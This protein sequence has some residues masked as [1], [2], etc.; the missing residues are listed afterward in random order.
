MN[1]MKNGAFFLLIVLILGLIFA[2]F[3]G[4]SYKE[5]YDNRNSNNS[6]KVNLDIGVT[7]EDEHNS[8]HK[9]NKYEKLRSGH[10]YDNYD[11][12]SK[13]S[14]PSTFYGPNG[15]K[16]TVSN[17][18][19]Q[20]SIIVTGSNGE[21]TTY[22]T[23]HST[24]ENSSSTNQGN[25][26]SSLMSNFSNTTFY[27]PNGGS[28]RFFTGSDGQHAIEIT[29]SNGDTI[30]YTST[31]TYTYNYT[32]QTSSS[33]YTAFPFANEHSQ[34]ESSKNGFKNPYK[35]SFYSS[36]DEPTATPNNYNSSLPAGIPR[37]MIPPGQEDLYILKSEVVPPVCPACPVASACPS[38]KQEKCPPCPACARCPEP[39]F[40]CK[41]VPNY[42]SSGD[43]S[44]LP[45][46][47]LSDFSTFGM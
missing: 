10:S 17:N 26:I 22:T 18:D 37:R 40:E 6:D 47:V 4:G 20:F 43:N 39:S 16:A 5:G 42:N 41:K 31:N 8:D 30:I 28:A 29:K 9:N 19:G 12:Y 46:P 34:S 23:T 44:Y 21:T 27:G 38:N 35:A 13:S 2:P 7:R 24:S 33:S 14:A 15:S 1:I 11:H 36:Y 32:G 45:V 25:S 3:L